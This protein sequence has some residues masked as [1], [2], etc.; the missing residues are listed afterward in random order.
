MSCVNIVLLKG[1]VWSNFRVCRCPISFQCRFHLNGKAWIS[2]VGFLNHVNRPTE[3]NFKAFQN[4]DSEHSVE[5]VPAS[6]YNLTKSVPDSL[7]CCQSFIILTNLELLE[8]VELKMGYPHIPVLV[9]DPLPSEYLLAQKQTVY[10]LE[11][12]LSENQTS[13]KELI[14]V[15]DF[16]GFLLTW[17]KFWSLKL[18]SLLEFFLLS[19]TSM[20]LLHSSSLAVV[21]LSSR[22][23]F[24]AVFSSTPCMWNREPGNLCILHYKNITVSTKRKYTLVSKPSSQKASMDSSQHATRN[25]RKT[26]KTQNTCA[27]NTENNEKP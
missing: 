2:R 21:T 1:K 5:G 12:K 25:T 9:P 7:T 18:S 24:K 26:W 15:F 6:L 4:L 14:L 13:T 23:I 27:E 17:Y 8:I 19:R 20:F 10:F 3:S 11:W 16:S 22:A